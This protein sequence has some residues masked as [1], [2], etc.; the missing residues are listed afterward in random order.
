MASA[1]LCNRSALLGQALAA[2]PTAGRAQASRVVT[3]AASARPVWFPGNKR[4]EHLDGDFAD[5]PGNF[6]FDPLSLGSD[7]ATLKW[8]QQAELVHSRWAMLG[9]AGILFPEIATKAGTWN[10]PIWTEAGQVWANDHPEIPQAALFFVEL[11]LMGWVETKRWQDFRNP[12]SQGDGSFF[13]ITDGF[14]GKGN[15]YPGGI[16]DPLGLSKGT[17]E[18]LRKY[19]ENEIKNGRL[20]MVA[21]L[22]FIFQAAAYPGKGPV[23]NLVDHVQA[24]YTTTF[25]TNG[26]SLP[27]LN[28][29][30]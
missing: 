16:F 23:Q 30:W 19:Q 18:Q 9:V 21:L 17:D 10:A 27:F 2:K 8:Y 14:K 28:P 4:P 22:G 1:L 29:N 7:P 15:G 25:A 5:A 20:A 12:G 26:V 13:G 3:Q 11:L 6:G 24:P